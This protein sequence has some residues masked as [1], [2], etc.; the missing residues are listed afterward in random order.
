MIK[1]GPGDVLIF[2]CDGCGK[3]V[4]GSA[5]YVHVDMAEV[6]E[7]ADKSAVFKDDEI[8]SPEVMTEYPKA[9]A[10]QVHHEACDPRPG[11]GDYWFG[12]DRCD[13][14]PK[15]THWTGHLMEK[16]WLAHTNWSS[17]LCAIGED[18]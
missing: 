4:T 15:L 9:V 12:V 16:S 18:A 8:L 5:G 13:T 6:N 2:E 17:I 7:A 1:R 14:W 3:A 10:W 11:S